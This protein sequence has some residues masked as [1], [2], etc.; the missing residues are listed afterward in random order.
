VVVGS[1][2]YADPGAAQSAFL[3]TVKK[4]HARVGR[5]ACL[6]VVPVERL[7]KREDCSIVSLACQAH[8]EEALACV[9]LCG[10]KISE[11]L[12][13]RVSDLVRERRPGEVLAVASTCSKDEVDGGGRISVK[14]VIL[15]REL[16]LAGLSGV[17]ACGGEAFARETVEELCRG[18]GLPLSVP[19][20]NFAGTDKG[21]ALSVWLEGVK[22]RRRDLP[23]PVRLVATRELGTSTGGAVARAAGEGGIRATLEDGWVMTMHQ[24]WASLV[25]S[26]LKRVEG[27]VWGVDFQGW[28]W[29][30]AAGKEM[31]EDEKAD[32]EGMYGDIYR[33]AGFPGV[34][35]PRTY[36]TSCLIGAVHIAGMAS[37]DEYQSMGDR[38]PPSV[39]E[40]SSSPFVFLCERPHRLVAAV[41]MRGAPKLWRL[42]PKGQAVELAR[43]LVPV[44]SPQPVVFPV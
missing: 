7:P 30:H 11:G 14:G 27:R 41:P 6:A 43:G 24:P 38:V 37:Y 20:G 3:V 32:I 29:I 15:G 22:E 18:G 19:R 13:A 42:S 40:E 33:G 1:G 17:I 12:A 21:N 23:A 8:R 25:V 26:G 10:E 44:P 35:F 28:L 34:T 36:P 9:F 16:V 31:L 2:G 5:S 39:L 4:I